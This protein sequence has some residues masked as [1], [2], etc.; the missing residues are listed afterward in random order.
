MAPLN[1]IIKIKRK[2]EITQADIFFG[3]GLK[4]ISW[5]SLGFFIFFLVFSNIF[6]L[7]KSIPN[8]LGQIS[9]DDTVYVYRNWQSSST[10]YPKQKYEGKF[11]HKIILSSFNMIVAQISISIPP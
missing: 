10:L 1:F 9:T 5:Y 6:F 7:I 2:G 3:K 4:L 11:I 8:N